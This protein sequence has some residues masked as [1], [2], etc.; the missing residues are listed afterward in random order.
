MRRSGD[1]LQETRGPGA[2]ATL[3]Y[4]RVLCYSQQSPIEISQCNEPKTRKQRSN[5]ASGAPL[6]PLL[7]AVPPLGKLNVRAQQV[8]R[9]NQSEGT[10]STQCSIRV[11]CI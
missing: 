9:R 4:N 5:D 3:L 6:S 11:W 7:L 2:G 1:W 8:H 10:H